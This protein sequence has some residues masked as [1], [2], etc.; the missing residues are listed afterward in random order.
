VPTALLHSL[1]GLL[2]VVQL[3]ICQKFAFRLELL[4]IEITVTEFF[5][6]PFPGLQHLLGFDHG[7]HLP[8]DARLDVLLLAYQVLLEFILFSLV[9]SLP[10]VQL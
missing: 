4:S 2:K 9:L 5:A 10:L 6:L 3:F 7:W 8:L 1:E